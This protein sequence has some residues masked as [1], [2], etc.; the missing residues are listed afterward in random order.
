MN[1]TKRLADKDVNAARSLLQIWSKVARHLHH[2][3]HQSCLHEDIILKAPANQA[4]QPIHDLFIFILGVVC[5]QISSR[6]FFVGDVFV[7]S[8][9][10]QYGWGFVT[11]VN[12]GLIRSAF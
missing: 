6:N 10:K 8:R 9:E 2:Y 12:K 7:L 1:E 4:Q 5:S 11:V 3:W